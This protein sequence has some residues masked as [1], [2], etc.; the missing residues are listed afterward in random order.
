MTDES[1]VRR[2]VTPRQA[3][4]RASVEAI[5]E[6]A[7]QIL[8]AGGEAAFNT[9][10]VAIRAGVSIGAVYRYFPD[11]LAILI[12]LAEREQGK[13]DAVIAEGSGDLAPDR[14]VIRAF[15]GAFEG[16]GAARRAAVRAQ[17]IAGDPRTLAAGFDRLPP[18]RDAAGLPLTAIQQFVLSR[19]VHGAMRAAVLE[20]QPFLHSQEFEDELVRLGRGYLGL[21]Q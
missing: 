17:L 15:L 6:A 21:T 10:A 1:P 7:A 13:V 8:Q 14:A 18:A 20:D 12:A 9:N 19:A 16:R 3:R 4:A 11:K 5:L 2:R